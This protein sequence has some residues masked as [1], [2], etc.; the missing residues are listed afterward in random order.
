MVEEDGYRQ[1]FLCRQPSIDLESLYVFCLEALGAFGYGELYGLAFLQSA[2]SVCLNSRKMHKDVVPG[3]SADK[4]KALCIIEPLH[5][6]LFHL[7]PV[8]FF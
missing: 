6:S 8:S 4:A 2:K 1:Q 5:C 7:L 3:M